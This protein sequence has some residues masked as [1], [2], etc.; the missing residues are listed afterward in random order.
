MRTIAL[1]IIAAV[2]ASSLHGTDEKAEAFKDR[3]CRG[4]PYTTLVMATMHYDCPACLMSDSVAGQ[5]V[6]S[7]WHFMQID[8]SDDTELR[9]AFQVSAVPTFIALINGHEVGRIEPD[10]TQRNY[11]PPTPQQL[12]ALFK[13]PSRTT[14]T[15]R[16][17]AR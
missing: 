12:A 17:Q 3:L 6:A 9:D 2:A 8:V 11:R 13:L 10:P 4:L 15:R 16:R 5:M 7:H 14:T 1:A